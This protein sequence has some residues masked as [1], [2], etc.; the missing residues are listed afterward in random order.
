M[1]FISLSV[2]IIVFAIYMGIVI[3]LLIFSQFLDYKTNF[4]KGISW[5]KLQATLPAVLN[6][7]V[8]IVFDAIYSKMAKVLTN[9]ENHQT[10]ISYEN[11]YIFKCYFLN[12]ISLSCPLVIIIFMG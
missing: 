11:H 3:V 10:Y 6:F 7:I 8:F 2:C 1:Y 5:L 12:I 9:M 4:P